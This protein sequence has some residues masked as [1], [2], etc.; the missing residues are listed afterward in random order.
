MKQKF[1]IEA[2]GKKDIN[3]NANFYN[4]QKE[5]HLHVNVISWL[6]IRKKW[7]ASTEC[8]LFCFLDTLFQKLER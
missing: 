2:N 4:L 8:A 7:L 1:Y 5:F 6:F 3:L